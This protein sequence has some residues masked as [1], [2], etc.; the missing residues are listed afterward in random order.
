MNKLVETQ[1]TGSL[2]N[3]TF[4]TLPVPLSIDD[5]KI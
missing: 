5:A 3:V 1:E 2:L 4:S